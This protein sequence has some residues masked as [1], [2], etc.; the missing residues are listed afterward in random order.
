MGC[1]PIVFDSF[2]A[3][4]DILSDGVNGYI[5][6]DVNMKVYVDRLKSL[7]QHP[8]MLSEMAYHATRSSRRFVVSRIVDDWE[9][10]LKN[11]ITCN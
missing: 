5:V 11:T 8:D 6:S 2:S 9:K 3:L 4:H 10:I 7:M 1:V